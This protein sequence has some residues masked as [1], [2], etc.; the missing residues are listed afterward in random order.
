MHERYDDWV[1]EQLKHND[2]EHINFEDYCAYYHEFHNRE[3]S[4]FYW[5]EK[6]D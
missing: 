5:S 1:S 3:L 6:D 2:Y 4:K